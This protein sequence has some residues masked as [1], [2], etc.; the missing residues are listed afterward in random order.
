MSG[1]LFGLPLQA[2]SGR[3]VVLRSVYLR[4]P[5][6]LPGECCLGWKAES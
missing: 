1:H 2:F 6:D 3:Q 5:R 4:V